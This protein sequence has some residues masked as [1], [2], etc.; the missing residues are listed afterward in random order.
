MQELKQ[1]T[2]QKQKQLLLILQKNEFSLLRLAALTTV[3]TLA[4]ILG[5]VAFQYIPSVEPLTPLSIL[6]GFFLGP[7]AGFASGAS[8]FYFSNFLVWGGQGPWTLF[9]ALGA[10]LAGFVGGLFGKLGAKSRWKALTSTV[11]GI[12]IYELVVTLGSSIFSLNPAFILFYFLTSLPFSFVHLV[13]SIG[14]M[15]FF[16]EFKE[17]VKKLKGGKIIEK[18]IF[19]F[20]LA[21]SVDGKLGNPIIPFLRAK[22]EHKQGKDKN[23]SKNKF[24]FIFKRK[25]D[26]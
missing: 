13:S 18:E 7:L 20:R 25:Q 1:K 12:S 2:K 3:L 19:G 11:I 26:D 9:Q 14:F 4:G 6:T 17:G 8:G 15:I 23:K 22:T 16:F 5:R 10:G 24:W 21:D